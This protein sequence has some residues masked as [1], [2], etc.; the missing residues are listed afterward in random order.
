ME[1]AENTKEKFSRA[2]K[3]SIVYMVIYCLLTLLAIYYAPDIL[4][5]GVGIIGGI[6]IFINSFFIKYKRERLFVNGLILALTVLCLGVLVGESIDLEGILSLGAAISVIDILSFTRFGKSTINAKAMSNVHFMSKLIVYGKGK[7]DI[8]IP[9]RG[10]GDYFYYAMW[11]AGIWNVSNRLWAYVT[12]AGMI[13]LG[14][15]I[16]YFI[17]ARLSRREGYKGFPAT[18]IPFICVA[19]WYGVLYWIF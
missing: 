13:F 2:V 1:N 5:A 6:Y 15:T 12:A 10:I 4:L 19:A 16:E 17:I 14:T 11:I 9:T 3:C 8:L 18:V 7:G